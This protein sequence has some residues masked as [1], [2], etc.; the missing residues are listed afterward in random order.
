MWPHA[1]NLKIP[2]LR[3]VS[4]RHTG[5]PVYGTLHAHKLCIKKKEEKKWGVN[6]TQANSLKIQMGSL[7]ACAGFF[8]L[9][10][11]GFS[12]IKHPSSALRKFCPT[13]LNQAFFAFSLAN[14]WRGSARWFSYD[15]LILLC[16]LQPQ[17]N[18]R[19]C[20][21]TLAHQTQVKKKDLR[22]PSF[23]QVNS[24]QVHHLVFKDL[25]LYPIIQL[26]KWDKK[27]S[28]QVSKVTQR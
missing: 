6:I 12:L 17:T 26:G 9:I 5:L 8:S 24:A 7:W 3:S 23:N 11:A 20:P 21:N 4:K 25:L 27:R 16:Y 2:F 15:D 19:S 1:R 10:L 28:G 18:R 22:I 13:T 14:L